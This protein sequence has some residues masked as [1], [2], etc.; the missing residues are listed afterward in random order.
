MSDYLTDYTGIPSSLI[1]VMTASTDDSQSSCP[2][3][4]ADCTQD[5]CAE[6]GMDNACSSDCSDCSADGI[7]YPTPGA[8][9]SIWLISASST[10]LT[11]GFSA[12]S[13]AD[14]YEVA[15][16]PTTT[17]S[18]SFVTTYS[19]SITIGGLSPN[20]DYVVNYRGYNDYGVGSFIL[21]AGPTFTTKP[22]LPDPWEWWS[23]IKVGQPINVSA[24]EW[25]AF[26][27]RVDEVR[28]AF[29]LVQW[30]RYTTVYSG[31]DMKASVA[32]DVREAIGGL[33]PVADSSLDPGW[34]EA[35][36]PITAAFFLGLRDYLN[37]AIYNY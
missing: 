34:I 12:V 32:E 26:T 6:C 23:T 9:T 8:A 19:T 20:T 35:N 15:Y 37:S 21:P 27:R 11:L 13:N 5:S 4:T 25:N 3:D 7:V 10:S 22:L 18:A 1:D 24:A 17:S 31:E 28:N 29:G 30:T 36:K 33:L 2:Y 14:Y 16:R